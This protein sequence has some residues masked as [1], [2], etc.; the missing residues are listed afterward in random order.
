MRYVST[1]AID[2]GSHAASLPFCDAVLTGLADDGGLLVPERIPSLK[3]QLDELQGCTYQQIAF[4][5]M[6]SFV[7]DLPPADLQALIARSYSSFNHELVTPLVAVGDLHILELFHGPT[8]AFKDIAL[9]FLGNLF[10]HTL[11]QSQTTLNLLGAT[12]GDTGSAAIAGVRG[13]ERINIFVL[14]P[15]GRVSPLQERQMTTVLDENVQSLAIQGSFDDCQTIVKTAFSDLAFKR[16]YHLGAVNSVNWA[17]ILAQVVYYFSAWVQLG[18]P[19]RFEVAVPTG[20]FGNIFAGYVAKAMGLPIAHLILATNQNDILH[21]F[22]STGRYHRGPVSATLSPAM[23]IQVASNFE[24]Y[25][26]YLFD[27]QASKVREFMQAFASKGVA[28]VN[29]NT[30][31]VDASF[32]SGSVSDEATKQT[33]KETYHQEGYLADPH[34]AVGLAVARQ[35]RDP[36]LPLVCLATAHPAKFDDALRSALGNQ[37]EAKHEAL[38]ALRDAPT[39]KTA[40]AADPAAVKAFIAAH[41]A[42]QG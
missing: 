3:A 12:S 31:S 16:Q 6:S 1:R 23:D 34:T 42:G 33:I 24:R 36:S 19:S 17:R 40:L 20:N 41:K 30:A 35:V 13:K 32:K 38:E 2:S 29:F 15:Q 7:D 5:V 8:L 28:S 11:Q 26:Y 10:E 9:Q 27:G 39:R 37:V 14:Y 22:F 25:L 21:R 18:C 4:K